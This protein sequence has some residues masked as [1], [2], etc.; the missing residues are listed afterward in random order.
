[1]EKCLADSSVKIKCYCNAT[2]KIS[3]NRMSEMHFFVCV[4]VGEGAA[5]IYQPGG[6]SQEKLEYHCCMSK[7]NHCSYI[8]A[9]DKTTWI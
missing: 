3:K 8:T 4:C 5:Q 7:M 1:M 9:L 2:P 6:G